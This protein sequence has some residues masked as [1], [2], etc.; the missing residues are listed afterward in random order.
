MIYL[1]EFYLPAGAAEAELAEIARAGVASAV[2]DGA[3]AR[4]IQVIFVPADEVCYAVY[5]ADSPEAVTA[6][7]VLAGLDFDRIGT[8]V[9][10]P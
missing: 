1:A 5:E 6:A 9:V 2:A 10:R 8:A 7:G 4:F 3:T